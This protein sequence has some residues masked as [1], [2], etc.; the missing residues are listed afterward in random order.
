MN[1]IAR[2]HK[3]NEPHDEKFAF[4]CKCGFW[5]YC[6]S[7]HYLIIE[8]NSEWNVKD[9]WGPKNLSNVVSSK[10]KALAQSHVKIWW[11]NGAKTIFETHMLALLLSHA[12][13][14]TLFIILSRT[15][16]CTQRGSFKIRS[17]LSNIYKFN[18]IDDIIVVRL[19]LLL[20]LVLLLCCACHNIGAMFDPTYSH[21]WASYVHGDCAQPLLQRIKIKDARSHSCNK[22]YFIL[23]Y[24]CIQHMIHW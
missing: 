4:K 17:S 20:L 16:K 15:W 7:H 8:I 2:G 23:V 3:F 10:K 9:R 14:L 6:H 19:L 1:I 22:V 13:I 12:L 11:R 5:H 24:L 21:F 18:F